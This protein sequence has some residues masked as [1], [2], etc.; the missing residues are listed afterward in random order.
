MEGSTLCCV[1][2]DAG[3]S[4]WGEEPGKQD[5]RGLPGGLSGLR[6][7]WVMGHL[8]ALAGWKQGLEVLLGAWGSQAG[9]VAWEFG[10]LFWPPVRKSERT[11]AWIWKG[12]CR[13]GHLGCV[14]IRALLGLCGCRDSELV[15]SAHWP[16]VCQLQRAESQ[17]S[18]VTSGL[19]R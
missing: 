4:G 2:W 8:E 9:P 3:S 19:L 1:V 7:P 10:L 6:Q 16:P 17:V 15:L 12:G 18:P 11:G 14:G 5:L 13:W